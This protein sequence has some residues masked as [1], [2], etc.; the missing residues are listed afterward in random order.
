M[1]TDLRLVESIFEQASSR[2]CDQD[3]P[4]ASEASAY[5]EGLLSIVRNARIA[6]VLRGI[7]H[8][9]ATFCESVESAVTGN[10]NL[11]R[12]ASTLRT[13]VELLVG[14]IQYPAS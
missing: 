7:P 11:E 13:A 4:A 10:S 8:T 2:I 9:L 3:I 12:Q 14:K 1:K 6:V 5:I